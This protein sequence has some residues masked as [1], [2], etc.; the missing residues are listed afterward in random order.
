MI[1]HVGWKIPIKPFF[2][3]NYLVVNNDDE[4]ASI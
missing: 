2:I 4:R 1:E 3:L